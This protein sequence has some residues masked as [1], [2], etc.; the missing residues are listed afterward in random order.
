MLLIVY[1]RYHPISP[2]NITTIRL[3]LILGQIPQQK[4]KLLTTSYYYQGVLAL[5]AHG[6]RI[7][8][9]TRKMLKVISNCT[10]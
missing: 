9:V 8:A 3:G 2:Y 5:V 4:Q 7:P 1:S 6:H 10:Q